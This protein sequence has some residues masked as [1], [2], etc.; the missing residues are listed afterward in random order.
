MCVVEG[1]P[2]RFDLSDVVLQSGDRAVDPIGLSRGPV[3]TLGAKATAQTTPLF[4]CLYMLPFQNSTEGFVVRPEG[5]VSLFHTSQSSVLVYL[6]LCRKR[7]S[8]ALSLIFS[9]SASVAR[10]GS[11]LLWR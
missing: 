3:P 5:M 7:G 4:Q 1:N 2:T 6:R 11:R 8:Q 9:R 10:R